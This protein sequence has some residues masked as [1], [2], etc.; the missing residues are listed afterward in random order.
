MLK[1]RYVQMSTIV[2]HFFNYN[3]IKNQNGSC[4]VVV[5]AIDF[6]LTIIYAILSIWK[7][8][9]ITTAVF[10]VNMLTLSRLMVAN[11]K[12]SINLREMYREAYLEK[13]GLL[14]K[15]AHDIKLIIECCIIGLLLVPF[16]HSGIVLRE[17]VMRSVSLIVIFLSFFEHFIDI[18]VELFEAS[19][20]IEKIK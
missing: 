12:H 13:P 8:D 1:K 14:F 11:L 20:T 18:L 19:M 4:H 2:L 10:A 3:Q 7:L 5:N 6:A 9:T 15:S 17:E 16:W